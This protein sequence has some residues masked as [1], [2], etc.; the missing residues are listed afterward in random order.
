MFTY[1][2]CRCLVTHDQAGNPV[3]VCPW[4]RNPIASETFIFVPA[5]CLISQLDHTYRV[6]DV[7]CDVDDDFVT[8]DE[9]GTPLSFWKTRAMRFTDK[10]VL[11]GRDFLICPDE[12]TYKALCMSIGHSN[13]PI[14][15]LASNEWSEVNDA[16]RMRS[17]TLEASRSYLD[18]KDKAHGYYLPIAERYME[19]YRGHRY[20]E[21]LTT[22]VAVP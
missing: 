2:A 3:P 5:G 15:L 6:L 1:L 19:R 17:L 20:S 12:H 14:G 16:L 13:Y 10:P 21:P 11:S 8:V 7:H 18:P 22:I 9:D 4:H